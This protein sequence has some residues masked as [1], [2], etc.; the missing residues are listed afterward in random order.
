MNPFLLRALWQLKRSRRV[1]VQTL[2]LCLAAWLSTFYV[3]LALTLLALLATAPH[4]GE[5]RRLG[6]LWVTGITGMTPRS[7]AIGRWSGALLPLTVSWGATQLVLALGGGFLPGLALSGFLWLLF[8]G[9]VGLVASVSRNPVRATTAALAW[10]LFSPLIPAILENPLP[11]A[12]K[13]FPSWYLLFIANPWPLLIGIVLALGY[14]T[15]RLKRNAP[16]EAVSPTLA[17]EARGL[18]PRREGALPHQ[19]PPRLEP[20]ATNLVD[21]VLGRWVDNPFFRA[22]RDGYLRLYQSA[23][24]APG[25]ALAPGLILCGLLLLVCSLELEPVGSLALFMVLTGIALSGLGALLVG[26]KTMQAESQGA[27][28]PLLL[29]SGMTPSRVLGGKF[30][31]AFYAIS[32]EW[33]VCWLGYVLVLFTR[34]YLVPLV[35]LHGA[36]IALGALLGIGLACASR[37]EGGLVQILLLLLLGLDLALTVPALYQSLLHFFG[38]G[39]LAILSLQLALAAILLM[40][41]LPWARVRLAERMEPESIR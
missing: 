32:G 41:V 16:L 13:V 33:R 34:P 37:R 35:L 28:W 25:S 10:L 9:A 20:A 4:F 36:V 11:G 1:W 38:L 19:A 2:V 22:Y 7:E 23:T 14:L 31:A 40:L 26:Y 24:D 21:R 6:S 17:G 18:A 8:V 3:Y 5:E 27:T 39:T 29:A 12:L 15:L 30:A